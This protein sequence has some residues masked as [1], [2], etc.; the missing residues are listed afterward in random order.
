MEF[1]DQNYC[2]TMLIGEPHECLHHIDHAK[3]FHR[4][5]LLISRGRGVT[6]VQGIEEFEKNGEELAFVQ[7]IV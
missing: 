5:I 7:T 1:A 3:I 2:Q 6:V 4:P